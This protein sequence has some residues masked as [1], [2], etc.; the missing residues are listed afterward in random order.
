MDLLVG[1]VTI[2][3]SRTGAGKCP[4][5]VKTDAP[6]AHSSDLLE[7]SPYLDEGDRDGP[8]YNERQ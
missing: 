8:N 5:S 4:R 6:R 7:P 3:E 1:Q 2:S